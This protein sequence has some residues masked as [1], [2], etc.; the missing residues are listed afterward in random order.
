[1]DLDY[2]EILKDLPV[3]IIIVDQLR[4]IE[5]ANKAA[6]QLLDRK[7]ISEDELCHQCIWQSEDVCVEC[8]F[9]ANGVNPLI[10]EMEIPERG[11]FLE[12][13]AQLY[14]KNYI[15][16]TITDISL[17]KRFQRELSQAALT[18][19]ASGL[20]RRHFLREHLQRE[21]HRSR[22]LGNDVSVALVRVTDLDKPDID[23]IPKTVARILRGVGDILG[24]ETRTYDMAYRFGRDTFA[25]ILPG[26]DL[27]GS[28]IAAKRIHNR[29]RELGIEGSKI[30][31]ATMSRAPIAEALLHAA[32]HALY[33]ADHSDEPV[34]TP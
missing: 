31:V 1:M 7:T 8:P 30:G 5:F 4:R 3:G 16:E 2:K 22:R 18:D 24:R 29:I 15:I 26:A 14:E 32:Q 28:V 17:R 27:A 11:R 10:R 12:I 33:K 20:L 6:L 23:N 19:P 13:C 21:M 34:A 25:V 9:E